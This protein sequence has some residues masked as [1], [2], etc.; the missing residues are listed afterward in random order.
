MRERAAK[1]DHLETGIRRFI[2]NEADRQRAENLPLAGIVFIPAASLDEAIILQR[3]GAP[4][5][6]IPQGETLEHFLYPDK[7]LDVVLDRKG[8]EVLQYVAPADFARLRAPLQVKSA[9]AIR[10]WRNFQADIR[11]AQPRPRHAGYHRRRS[12][13]RRVLGLG[14]RRRACLRP[15]HQL[16]AADH[17]ERRSRCAP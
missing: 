16:L 8:K 17:R 13:H 3:F 1:T 7:G 6:R 9:L 14:H 12:A 5:E 2:L 4:A 11:R 10:R 15:A